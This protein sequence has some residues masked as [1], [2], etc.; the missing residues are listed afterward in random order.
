MAFEETYLAKN[1]VEDNDEDKKKAAVGGESARKEKVNL[2]NA[3]E[4]R[5]CDLPQ[6]SANDFEKLC[7]A[8]SLEVVLGTP[9]TAP[10]QQLA[11][12]AAFGSPTAR[13]A[14]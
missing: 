13:E 6:M 4:D 11:P 14:L 10:D 5:M 8:K 1:A 7:R 2:R 12:T 9:A 3:L